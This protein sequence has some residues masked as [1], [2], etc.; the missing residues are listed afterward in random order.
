MVVEGNSILYVSIYNEYVYLNSKKTNQ[1]YIYGID[2]LK[3]M[4]W[5]IALRSKSL[6]KDTSLSEW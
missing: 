6:N 5:F 4:A 2:Q 1:L 3:Y